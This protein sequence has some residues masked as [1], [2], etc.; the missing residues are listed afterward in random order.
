MKAAILEEGSR[1]LKVVEIKNPSI[2]D[3]EV[4]VK[5]K[6]AGVCHTDLH[7]IN[8]EL[9]PKKYPV[10]LGHQIA[11][12][13]IE[14][15][16]PDFKNGNSVGHGW[17][18]DTC[19]RCSLC[20]KGFTN[21]CY[22]AKFTGFDYPGGFAEYFVSNGRFLFKLGS[23]DF[24]VTAPLMCAGL[25]AYR[26]FKLTGVGKG[27]KIG[28]IGFGSSAHILLKLLTRL[29]IKA[30][31]FTSSPKKV[32]FAEKLGAEFAGGFEGFNGKLDAAVIFSPAGEHIAKAL[33]VVDRGG[34]V[35]SAAIHMSDVKFKYSKIYHEK[36]LLSTANFTKKDAV[37]FLQLA[38]KFGIK[39]DVKVYKLDRINDAILEVKKRS[40]G[41]IVIS[42]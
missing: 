37:E 16:N 15:K 12:I 8:S 27:G 5:V 25:I 29:G 6:A 13:V 42:C 10:I 9:K 2:K 19:Y 3:G 4:L 22:N 14:S 28:L 33:E 40:I 31:V 32:K 11:G 38:K 1:S 30:Y 17:I 20:K 21:L 24:S 18:Y 7:I 39:A 41:S 23:N 35:V 26:A 34:V 36:K